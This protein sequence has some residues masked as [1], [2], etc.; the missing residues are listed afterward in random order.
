MVRLWFY[1]FAT[2]L[3]FSLR[4]LLRELYFVVTGR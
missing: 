2:G 1:S 3:G 4:D